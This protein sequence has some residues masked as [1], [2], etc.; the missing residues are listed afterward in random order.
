MSVLGNYNVEID[1]NAPAR[2]DKIA[3]PPKRW[4]N[5]YLAKAHMNF[6]DGLIPPVKP[7]DVFR[8]AGVW[9]SKEIAEEKAKR[10]C[11]R[12]PPDTICEYLGAEPEQDAH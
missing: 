12:T 2:S 3:Q 6:V 11:K 10:K 4:R 8:G 9:P 1:V 5:W 7:G